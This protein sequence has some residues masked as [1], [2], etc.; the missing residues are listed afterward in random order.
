MIIH[1]KKTIG[2]LMQKL[3]YYFTTLLTTQ[4]LLSCQSPRQEVS[5]SEVARS[6]NLWTGVA[7]SESDR[8]FVNYPRW[9]PQTTIS[10]AEVI[11]SDSTIPYPD[12]EWNQWN[13]D[14]NPEDHFICVQS[15]YIDH[16]NFLW[17][18]DPANP[19]FQGVVSGGPKLVKIDLQ[20]DRIVQKISFDNRIAPAGSYLNDVRF[21]TD[22]HFAYITDSGEGAIVVV[23]L[24]SGEARRLL[25]DHF[26]TKAENITFTVEGQKLNIKVHSDGLA[27]DPQNEF[28][29]YQALTGKSLYRIHTKFLRDHSISKDELKAKV[30][31]VTESGIS[32]AVEFDSKGNL[33]LTSLEYNAIRK[34][35]P[36]GNIE[37]V[38]QHERLKWPDSFSIKADGT[39]Y[40]TTSQLHLGNARIEP[41]RVFK[42][43]P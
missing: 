34:Y 1:I 26:S 32:D 5:L 41:Y 35:T 4:F 15:V 28:L 40:V 23:N 3:F 8:I 18:L 24:T 6:E 39:I 30:E 31:F 16:D 14:L 17:I 22:R 19:L 43:V 27:L 2:I 12:E 9:S 20:N 33:Y 37:I 25:G 10:V 11:S 29:Y 42:L 36:Q 38:I 21:D 13:P 7:V